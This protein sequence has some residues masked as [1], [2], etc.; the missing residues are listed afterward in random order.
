[1]NWLAVRVRP[2]AARPQALAAL[3]RAGSEGVHEAGDELVT[4]FPGETDGEAVRRAVLT[5][6]LAWFFLDSAGSIASGNAS[7]ALFNVF[8]L[9]VAVGPLWW[10]AKG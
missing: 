10:P 1:M 6:I 8:V 3:F 5:G 7:N 4:H 9:L 2:G